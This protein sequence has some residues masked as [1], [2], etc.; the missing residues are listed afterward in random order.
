MHH[1][2]HVRT[3][4]VG[5][6]PSYGPMQTPG[7][8]RG[9]RSY[10]AGILDQDLGLARIINET[11]Q[12]MLPA[13]KTGMWVRN[14]G[15]NLRDQIRKDPNPIPLQFIYEAADCRIFFT[16]KTYN[17]YT[18]LWRYA[19]EAIWVDPSK[20]VKDS[21]GYAKYGS[22]TDTIG[23]PQSAQSANITHGMSGV[24]Q[25]GGPYNMLPV[26]SSHALSDG[27][28][29]IQSF[30]GRVC[31][32]T[33]PNIIGSGNCPP[34]F[35]CVEAARC[36]PGGHPATEYQCWPI[37]FSPTETCLHGPCQFKYER[38]K[39]GY[40]VGTCPSRKW[41]SPC[42]VQT[43]EEEAALQAYRGFACP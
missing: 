13:R 35:N 4:V 42:G 27:S 28:A 20:C 41:A 39:S 30:Q 37:C 29:C 8:T 40:W 1:Q 11:T 6:R 10:A 14:A 38:L 7:G 22:D 12:G 43:K 24:A 15:F 2:A 32:P 34:N 23:P 36:D 21:T 26:S 25:I 19:A 31:T 18:L 16:K 9:A 17:N 3:V 33:Q 5:G